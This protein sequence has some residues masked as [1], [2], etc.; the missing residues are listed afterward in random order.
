M[1]V[2]DVVNE[3]MRSPSRLLPWLLAFTACSPRAVEFDPA[4][5]P[6]KVDGQATVPPAV[7]EPDREARR[8]FA[9]PGGMW[10]P[11]QMASHVVTLRELGMK[12]DPQALTD[13]LAFPLGAIVWLG[14][15]TGSFVSPDG[16][17][18]TNHHCATGA[19]QF[20]STKEKDLLRD[21]YLARTRAEERSNGPAAR[22]FVTRSVRDV[23]Q[24]VRG[25]LGSVT[26]AK[27]RFDRIERRQK[28]LVA[29]CE[30]G[31]P[32][33]RCTV[34][35]FF[36]GETY[37]LVEQLELRDIRLVYAPAE[38]VGNYGGEIDNWRWP[39]HAGDF[40]FFRA[41][42]DSN[43]AP[44]D[45]DAK[46]VP[47]RPK[48]HL[49]I[50]KEALAPGDLVFVA[51]YPGRTSRLKTAAEV[52]EAVEWFY[53]RRIR[54]CEE[55]IAL[56]DRLA[57]EDKD[58]EIKGRNLWRGLSN[59]L[60]NTKGQL[61][62]LVAD[63]LA[64]KKATL[65][66]ELR[67]WAA[68]NPEHAGV[69]SALDSLAV[70]HG[71]HRQRREEEAAL[72]EATM[73]STL[74]GAADTIVHM[75]IERPKPDADRDPSFQER[76]HK[77]LVQMQRQQQQSYA[78]RLEHEKLK[79]ALVRAA[80]LP[81]DKRPKL[82][83]LVVPKG[84]PTPDAIDKALAAMLAKTKLEDVETRVKLF[85]TATLAELKRTED[86]FLKLALEIRPILQEFEDLGES[87]V[88]ETLNSRVTY[89]GGLR[90]KAGGLLAPDANATLR[91]TYG[92]VRGYSPKPG[93]PVYHPFT[94]LSEMA[95]KHTGQEPFDAPKGLVEAARSG[96]FGP[97]VDAALG[98]VPVDFLADLD[99][100][101]GNSGSPT[102]NAK[103]ELVGLVFDGNY[104][105]MASDWL[106]M[107]P[108]T[109][110]IHVDV[111][112]PLWIMDRV[113][114]ADHLLQELGLTPSL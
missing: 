74:L 94:K 52:A 77:R 104:E 9:N 30:K 88:G 80:G 78:R 59:A 70:A 69:G 109:R 112:Y 13:P 65:E 11:A 43:Q 87:Y 44:A 19:L 21:G 6:T 38:G 91:L 90:A 73:M 102:L 23:T 25:D 46:N 71:K 2:V 83:S 56:L 76:N 12:L 47:Y 81:A 51:G 5:D 82:L 108:I 4:N 35:S 28:D 14:G 66:R 60:T 84:E 33:I 89:I 105:A 34:S 20:N 26:D 41:Y 75:A 40:T 1:R 103:G 36:D 67:A 98:E 111:R 22:V 29:A 15:C 27:Q 53:P 17:I 93:A 16:L 101:G 99:I 18:A 39:R 3:A 24:E 72:L 107:P 50:A 86:P 49:P 79:L 95:A 8:N 37:M 45:F 7:A 57:K 68:E 96:P 61:D 55:Y 62:G 110:S 10:T 58:L 31:H 106:F 64:A 63:G 48:H 114:G 54:L 42:V 97:Y 32:E 100:T 85:E 92:T 113:D